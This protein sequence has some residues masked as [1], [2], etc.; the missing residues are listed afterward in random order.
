MELKHETF[1]K[2]DR[3]MSSVYNIYFNKNKTN[4]NSFNKI[5]VYNSP[6]NRKIKIPLYNTSFYNPKKMSKRINYK[7]IFQKKNNYFRNNSFI[8][9][10]LGYI[11]SSPKQISISNCQNNTIH[12]EIYIKK[13][14]IFSPKRY[15]SEKNLKYF[16]KNCLGNSYL[17]LT[18]TKIKN[19]YKNEK[20]K[21]TQKIGNNKKPN[22]ININLYNEKN[23]YIKNNII[24]KIYINKN[25]K[26]YTIVDKTSNHSLNSL[27]TNNNESIILSERKI[28]PKKSNYSFYYSTNNIT[29]KNNNKLKN[30][31]Y[32]IT[33]KNSRKRMNNL[34]KVE[35]KQSK[36]YDE[37]SIIKIQSVIRGYLLNKKLDKY[38]R[39]YIKINKAIKVIEK[40][41]FK[42]FYNFIKQIKINH[43]FKYSEGR[44]AETEI[45][46]TKRNIELQFKINELINEKKELQNNYENLK[47]FIKKFKELE[48]ENKKLRIENEKLKQKN[49]EL[50]SIKINKNKNIPSNLN[51]YKGYS[52]Q[53]QNNLNIISKNKASLINPKYKNLKLIEDTKK[54]D[55]KIVYF[56]LGNEGKDNDEIKQT[57]KDSLKLK[58]LR[59]LIKNKECY[60]KFKIF[61]NFVKFYYNGIYIQNIIN[62]QNRKSHINIINRRYNH[63]IE[64]SN[65]FNCVSLK[66]L[67]DN[68]SVFTDKRSQNLGIE[69]KITNN[70]NILDEDY[71]TK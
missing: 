32:V 9:F 25:K 23:N 14:N 33:T 62:S 68:S 63:N 18:P 42:K 36:R 48:K 12:P 47:E 59:N 15:A 4:N 11:P 64:N 27:T 5:P 20:N 56:T 67:S 37:Y 45:L 58:K 17:T 3:P 69:N 65:L 44:I 6:K 31:G 19:I 52:I 39:N 61:K 24:N 53:K 13:I 71:K 34:P 46:N 57:E 40:I 22:I 43:K 35:R 16:F 10:P 7:M 55:N 50:L 60:I 38:L 2:V 28:I 8:E 26:N 30:K 54:D 51:K 66:T 70:N 21:N 41:C 1:Y 49:R 29:N